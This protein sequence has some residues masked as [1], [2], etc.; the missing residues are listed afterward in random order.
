MTVPDNRNM[1]LFPEKINN[2]FI[3]LERSFPVYSHGGID[4]FDIWISTSPDCKYWGEAELLLKMEDVSWANDKL[5]PGA[6]P[7]KTEKGWLTLFHG[8]DIDKSRGKNGWEE[9]WQKRYSLGIMLLDLANPYKI[10]AL[11]QKPLL[12]PEKEYETQ[13]GFRQNVIFPGGMVL[14]DSGEVKIYYGAADTVECLATAHVNDLI[15]LCT[16]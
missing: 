10:K 13:K 1:V 14:E 11:Y 15:K 2:K 4:K 3:R 7:I 9:K 16:S 8:V 5:G 6:P 12:I